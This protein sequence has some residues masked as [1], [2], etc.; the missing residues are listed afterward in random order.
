MAQTELAIQ[1]VCDAGPLIHLDELGC[2]H[3]LADFEAVLVPDAVWLEVST[4]RPQVLEQTEVGLARTQVARLDDIEF[5]T[6]VRALSLDLGERAALALAYHRAQALLLTDDA[7][8]RLAAERLNIRVQGTLGIVLR[9]TRRGM[10][11]PQQ[12][13][14]VLESVPLRSSLFVRSDL[15]NAVIARVRREFSL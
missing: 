15:L 2:L 11:T 14:A 6:L 10:Y 9:A 12:V 4:H 5:R 13:L 8:A 3:L 1:V 7:A